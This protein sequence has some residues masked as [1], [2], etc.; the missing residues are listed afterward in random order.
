MVIGSD[1]S[2]F[3]W[4]DTAIT[5]TMSTTTLKTGA[6]GE[7]V[8]SITWTAGGEKVTAPVVLKGTIAPPTA[9]WRLTHPFELGR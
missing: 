3:T 5:S 4:S 9:W 2:A 7:K 8:G 6:D 1:A